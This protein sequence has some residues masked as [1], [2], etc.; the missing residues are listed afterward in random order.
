V[1]FRVGK[2]GRCEWTYGGED[3]YVQKFPPSLQGMESSPEFILAQMDYV[4]TD[5][6]LLHNSGEYGIT[7]GYNSRA[8]QR[9]PTR[10]VGLAQADERRI[11]T[12]AEMRKLRCLVEELGLRGV[13]LGTAGFA[14]PPEYFTDRRFVPFWDEVRELDIILYT[15]ADRY[16]AH[17]LT[18]WAQRYPEIPVILGDFRFGGQSA[19]EGRVRIAEHIWQLLSP[20]NILAEICPITYGARWEYPYREVQAMVRPL[21]EEFGG[22]KFVWGSDIP[23]LERWCTY[24]QGL[25]FLRLHFDFISSEDMVLILGGNAFRVLGLGPSG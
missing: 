20:P 13:H 2:F 11:H 9:Y 1:D 17:A 23:N 4:G 25:D 6:A 5:V 3:Y 15:I 7:N 16:T 14:P 12:R 21:Y 22:T 8:V 18:A 10:F 19:R 24:L